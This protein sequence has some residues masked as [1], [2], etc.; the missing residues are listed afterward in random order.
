MYVLPWLMLV[1]NRKERW[2]NK[3]DYSIFAS[4][5]RIPLQKVVDTSRGGSSARVAM[6]RASSGSMAMHAAP[7][8]PK[9]ENRGAIC[10]RIVRGP[11]EKRE[12][13]D[14]NQ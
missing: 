9:K 3:A 7:R 6:I 10:A 1:Q 14:R 12:M 13:G 8:K 5:E 2:K 11:L 4:L